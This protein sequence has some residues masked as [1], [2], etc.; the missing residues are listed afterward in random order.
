MFFGDRLGHDVPWCRSFPSSV[1]THP[2][3]VG[4]VL[5]IWGFALVVRF[6]ERDWVLVPML[7]TVFYVAGAYLEGRVIERS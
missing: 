5:S 7:E 3:Y 6:P 2:Q 1:L 4:A